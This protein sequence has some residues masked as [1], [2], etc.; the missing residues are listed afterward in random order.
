MRGVPAVTTRFVHVPSAA[1]SVD[2][3]RRVI[4]GVIVP[5]GEVGVKGA[6]AFRFRRGALQWGEVARVKLLRDHDV[7]RAVGVTTSLEDSPE[8]LRAVFRVAR[9]REGDEVLDLAEDGVLDGLSVGVDFGDEDTTADPRDR[10]VLVV[11]R[12]DLREVSLTAM[13]SFDNARVTR[14]AASRTTGVP[15]PETAEAAEAAPGAPQAAFTLDQLAAARDLFERPSGGEPAEGPTA[16]NPNPGGVAAAAAVDPYDGFE[17]STLGPLMPNRE[18]TAELAR[19]VFERRP[20]RITAE[21]EP[22]ETFAAVTTTGTGKTKTYLG[23]RAGLNPLRIAELAGIPTVNVGW[24]GEAAFPV[25]GAGAAGT[26][27]EAAAKA[28]YAAV[29][30]GSKTPQTIGVWTDMSAQA[31]SIDQ[32]EAKLRLKLARLIAIAGNE[33]LRATVAGTAG[34]V[35]QGFTAG[36]QAVQILRAAAGIE[37]ANGVVP[38]VMLFNPADTAAIF[39]TAVSN[40]APAEIAELS[41]RTFGMI[42]LPLSTQP[43]GF[44]LLGAWAAASQ[45]VIGIGL[46]YVV[47][48]LT[49]LKNKIVTLLAEEAVNLA[50]EEPT[51]FTSVDIVTP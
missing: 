45:F 19:A 29:T 8:G 49:Q 32:F 33:L 44:V 43:A 26:P 4:E 47:D 10:R 12:A 38:D 20:V 15:V 3:G 18:Q 16:V 2:A 25:F 23:G 42:A 35:V 34:I 21:H 22:D 1:L 48:P 36:D 5:Y 6:A 50:V 39:G 13:P 40:A 27:L 14:V 46:T 28:E 51:G 9:G 24:G 17:R 37:A 30:A 41:M 31:Q 11:G 7:R